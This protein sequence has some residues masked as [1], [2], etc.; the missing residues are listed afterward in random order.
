MVFTPDY[1]HMVAVLDNQRPRRLPIYEHLINP[2][3]MELVLDTQFAELIAG[4]DADVDEFFRQYCR[5]YREM[6]YDTVSFEVCITSILPDS[7]ALRGGRPGPI[8]NRTDFERYPWDELVERYWRLADRQ[9][10]AL[11][12]HMP[13]G[14]K[15]VG[16]VGN[17]AFEISEDLVGF[18]YLCYLQ[19]DDPDLFTDLF[20]RIGD[21]MV[22]I[23]SGFLNRYVQDFAVCR[24]G[25][26]LGFKTGTL[27]AP[28]TL[29]D[30]IIPE[31]RR[32]I[33][34]V[35]AADRRFLWHSCGN[36]FAVM[37]N[38]IAA[39]IDC[40]HSNED[41]IAPFDR[42]IALYADRIALVG[43][44]DVDVLCKHTP[45]IILSRVVEQGRRYRSTAQGY[46]LGSGNSIPEYVPV[47]GYLAMIQAA[48]E[49]RRIEGL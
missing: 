23:W 22:E 41:V 28:N 5:F 42:W 18:E 16:G 36:I 46:A 13:A 10:Q 17:G 35:H 6:T 34:L 7:G 27:L 38:A 30:Y 26:D 12:R 3:F 48:Q 44:I 21:L 31:Y 39:G 40:K 33:D 9:F 32:V 4:D 15:A 2:E 37:E 14:M 8:Q 49:I 25:D 20:R 43:G 24:F 11:R 47:E 45:E 19:V 29:V 1:R